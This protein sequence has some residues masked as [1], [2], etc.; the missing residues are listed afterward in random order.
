MGVENE[1][2]IEEVFLSYMEESGNEFETNINESFNKLELTLPSGVYLLDGEKITI[3]ENRESFDSV[4]GVPLFK[5][6]DV[7]FSQQDITRVQ[8]DEKI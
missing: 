8:Q 7:V 2:L 4:L 3:K 1:N 6:G 5:L